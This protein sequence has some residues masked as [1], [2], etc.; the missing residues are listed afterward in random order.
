MRADIYRIFNGKAIYVT[1][2][3]MMLFTILVVFVFRTAPQTGVIITDEPAAE[4]LE[5]TGDVLE[6]IG[7]AL[8][9]D[10]AD[11]MNGAV[12]ARIVILSI[13][14]LSFFFLVLICI[15]AMDMFTTGA[16][17]N[18][19]SS[20]MN[21]TKLY[22]AKFALSSAFCIG[23][24][25]LYLLASTVLASLI[26]GVGYWGDGLLTYVFV[27]FSAQMLLVLAL[28]SVGMFLGFVTRKEGAVI[29]LFLA[30]MYAP[31]TIAGLLSIAFPYAMDIL[32]YD[33]FSQF[34]FLS[35]AMS[36]SGAELARS[37][38]ICMIFILV[39]TIVGITIFRRTEIK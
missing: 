16:I 30:V 36:I 15:I 21:R 33:L 24:M 23:F 32:N 22:L 7:E 18:E 26:D 8:L 4:T 5:T 34:G 38:S 20:G 3:I 11:T 19:L 6:T 31:T 39:P 13:D 12:A 37:I 29:G 14:N 1:F 9:P 28:N 25:F 2:A 17:K 27:S 10:R 35:Q